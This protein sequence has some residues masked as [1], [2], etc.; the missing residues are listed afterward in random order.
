MVAVV[1]FLAWL[2]PISPA[3]AS[4]PVL[5][6]AG[7][8]ACPAGST[9]DA[10]DC[11]QASTAALISAHSPTAIAVL[12][13]EQYVNG[14]LA[15]FEGAG[16]YGATWGALNSISH[17]VPGNHEYAASSTADG[18]FTYFGE[19]AV[20]RNGYYSYD[21]GGWHVIAL[22]SNCG[23]GQSGVTCSNRE[24]GD[25][26]ATSAEVQWL[27][28]DLAAHQG[29]CTLAYW[30]HPRFSQGFSG[31]SASTQSLWDALYGHGADVVLNG[32]D[33]VYERYA[34]LGSAGSA[35]NVKG[36]REFVAGEGGYDLGGFPSTPTAPVQ[37]SD[38]S[39]FG[40]LFLTLHS[41]AYDWEYD[42]IGNPSSTLDK[43][44][45]SVGCHE[46]V[47]SASASSTDTTTGQPVSFD[48]H[49]SVD[50]G[51]H[52]QSYSWDF[53]DGGSSSQ[54]T[55]SHTYA[56]AGTYTVT[57]TA[58]ASNGVSTTKTLS[59][60]V[61]DR[62]PTAAFS[63]S[64][65]AAT[66]QPVSFDASASADPDGTISAY[67]WDFGDGSTAS[68]NLASHSYAMSGTYTA[69]LTVTDNSGNTSSVTHAVTVTDRPPIILVTMAPNPATA[70]APVKFDAT[71]SA[72]PDGAI[73]SYGWSF[74]DGSSA[75]GETAQHTYT[76]SGTFTVQVTIT[77]NSGSVSTATQTLRVRWPKF[78]L[79]Q[80][81]RR[82]TRTVLRH[83]LRLELAGDL[84][85]SIT[86]R[87]TIKRPAHGHRHHAI[88]LGT[89]SVQVPGGGKR[90]LVVVRLDRHAIPGRSPRGRLHVSVA[91]TWRGAGFSRALHWLIT[92][93]S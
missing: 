17:P 21:V 41:G 73:T 34:Q 6:A 33:H 19:A 23:D 35:D 20:S 32:H 15:E 70:G 64:P 39:H 86:L 81:D 40:I 16:A 48:A 29:Q 28:N 14:T 3:Q 87:L 74:G 51:S 61:A 11:Q 67:S 2:V 10:G 13:D 26:T 25:G 58:M 63:Y 22:N 66:G 18:Y 38:S 75:S 71:G 12:G 72:D 45:S 79:H 91:G 80:L 65:A 55:P 60:S 5:A 46:P 59:I 27:Q 93:R 4:D 9:T 54:A 53:G 24:G 69:T 8:I 43:S 83:G 76:Q 37:S 88:L 49:A 7:D 84:A 42:S 68:G 90:A 62:P 1:A 56:T 50:D 36:I 57:A 78:S 92:L 47:V 30:H 82:L 52:I 77:D 89:A 85:G 44:S 31:G